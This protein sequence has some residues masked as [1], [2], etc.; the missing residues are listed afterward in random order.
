MT[1]PDQPD[2]R[3]TGKRRQLGSL[4]KKAEELAGLV[5]SDVPGSEEKQNSKGE[6]GKVLQSPAASS[7]KK[8]AGPVLASLAVLLICLLLAGFAWQSGLLSALLESQ[9]EEVAEQQTIEP[10]PEPTE[11]IEPAPTPVAPS[12][13]E[14]LRTQARESLNQAQRQAPAHDAIVSRIASMRTELNRGNSAYQSGNWTQAGTAFQ[15]VIEKGREVESLIGQHQQALDGMEAVSELRRASE[16]SANFESDT[17]L[18]LRNREV[19]LATDFQA[20]NFNEVQRAA[21][22]LANEYRQWAQRRDTALNRALIQGRQAIS[23][24]NQAQA[25]R[26]FEEA[27]AIK[28]D[29]REA[30]E[31]LGRARTLDQVTRLANQAR[32]AESEDR[33]EEAIAYWREALELDPLFGTAQ[34][35]MTRLETELKNRRANQLKARAEGAA[36]NANWDEAIRLYEQFQ[37]DFPDRRDEVRSQLAQ[38]REEWEQLATTRII[39]EGARMEAAG[40]W[41]GALEFYRNAVRENPNN[42]VLEAR[43][44][45]TIRIVRA[46]IRFQ[47]YLNFALEAAAEG[48]FRQATS[49][50]NEAVAS[51][52]S[53]IPLGQRG[54]ELQRLLATQSSPVEV[55]LTSDNRTLV[56]I[57]GFLPPERFRRKTISILPGNYTVRGTRQ[58]FRDVSV[59]LRVRADED[60]PR[61]N[62][63]ANQRLR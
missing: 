28:S 57:P 43:V 50:F 60:P 19:A 25:I 54:E 40:N 49:L 51:K 2:S 44:D 48:D 12:E 5:K 35:Q 45:R 6:K 26:S 20:G 24:S 42:P 58:D 11:T 27:L 33:L 47:T 53:V 55:T 1:P 61:I 10:S 39:E 3:P 16:S 21:S 8:T 18:S 56:S 30:Q 29:S 14:S 31:G 63:V 62:I 9:P 4:G 37:S 22:S 7:K 41:Q 17:L 36:N 34:Q 52:P 23:A 46:K 32:E 15:A 38:A 59:Q 13:L